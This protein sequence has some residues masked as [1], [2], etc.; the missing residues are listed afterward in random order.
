MPNSK[1]LH[2]DATVFMTANIRDFTS[3]SQ[4]LIPVQISVQ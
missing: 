4:V 2:R 3:D 1:A